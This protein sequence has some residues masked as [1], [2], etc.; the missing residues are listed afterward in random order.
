[1]RGEYEADSQDKKQNKKDARGASRFSAVFVDCGIFGIVCEAYYLPDIRDNNSMISGW[2]DF[3]R[4]I[5]AMAVV[6]R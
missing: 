2:K 5:R 4:A 3:I 6:I 1:M